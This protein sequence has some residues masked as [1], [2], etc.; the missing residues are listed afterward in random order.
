MLF[1]HGWQ[2]T[3]RKDAAGAAAALGYPALTFS[4]PGHNESGGSAEFLTGEI[5]VRAAARAY[6][7]LLHLAG[8]RDVIVVG[9]SFG[10]WI[11]VHLTGTR[12]VAAL[13]LRVPANYPDGA[14]RTPLTKV[15]ADPA[16][17]RAWRMAPHAAGD[18]SMLRLLAAFGG[19][20][21][22]IRAERDATIPPQTTDQICRAVHP[23]RLSSHV[24][25][26]APHNLDTPERAAAYADALTSWLQRTAG[27]RGIHRIAHPLSLR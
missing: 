21:Q 7:A 14:L 15:L 9:S 19:P 11:A 10:A 3:E 2:G 5:A 22:V 16:A 6:D 1:L 8:T 4:F 27:R 25:A 17:L 12:D 23:D 13:S 26:G 18:S 24:L 20:V